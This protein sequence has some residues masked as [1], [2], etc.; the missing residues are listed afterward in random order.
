LS[1]KINTENS[2]G[3]YYGNRFSSSIQLYHK[4]RHNNIFMIAPNVGFHFE[5]SLKDLD[6]GYSVRPTGGTAGF[7]TIGAELQVKQL[8]LSCN[9]QPVLLEVLVAGAVKT[10]NSAMIQL[11][12]LL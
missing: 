5:Q 1:Y 10:G 11:S 6:G 12:V 7:G 4:F 8:S 2:Y 3:Y 9:W